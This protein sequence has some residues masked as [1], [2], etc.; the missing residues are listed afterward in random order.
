MSGAETK[1]FAWQPITP[2]GVGSFAFATLGRLLLVQLGCAIISAGVVV[3]CVHASWFPV[4]RQAI[5]QMPPQ[6]AIRSGKLDWQTNSPQLLAA[7]RFLSLT[8][9]LKHDGKVRSPAHLQVEFG[10]TDMKVITVFGFA[11]RAYPKGYTILFNRTDLEPWWGAW[12]P[13]ILA[14]IAGGVIAGL[15]VA[16]A[17]LATLYCMPVWLIAFFANR[18]LSPGASWRVAG[19]ALMPGALFHVVALIFY[20]L[21]A[22][23]LLRLVMAAALHLVV[24]WIYL[25]LGPL[26]LPRNSA[27]PG[28]KSN[29]FTPK[30]PGPRKSDGA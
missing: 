26:S 24:G 6:G 14:M 18:D 4:V 29:P 15:F 11:Q 20:G 3:W 17:G 8:V 28:L 2:R 25:F 27:V 19:A 9:D 13:P 30:A 5:L 7:S 23:D 21:G 16:W 10:Q 22:L 1:P 12:S